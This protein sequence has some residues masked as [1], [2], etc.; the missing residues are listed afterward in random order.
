LFLG[1]RVPQLHEP[2]WLRVREWAQ[3]DA[4]HDAEDC[5]VRAD[6]KGEHDDRRQRE[7]WC[8]QQQ[9]TSMFEIV[10]ETG[11]SAPI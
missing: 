6:A 1:R 3:Q 8:L 9:S 2:V 10:P 5:R 11:H 7:A 4:V